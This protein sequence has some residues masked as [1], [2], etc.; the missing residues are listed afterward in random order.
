MLHELK[1]CGGCAGL[2][3]HRRWCPRA[4]GEHAA[5]WGQL[6]VKAEALGDS[7]GPNDMEASSMAWHIGAM[8]RKR[9]EIARDAY[10]KGIGR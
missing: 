1:D 10:E 8:L 7:I 5:Y 9:A 6:S 4:V 2:G 3:A